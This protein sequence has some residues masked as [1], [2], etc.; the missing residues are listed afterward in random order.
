[1]RKMKKVLALAAC[2]VML[3]TASV[4]G[5]LAY[6]TSTDDVNN[7]F[8]VGKVEITLDEARVNEYGVAVTPAVRNDGNE[9]K[10]VPG[11]KY[12]KDPTIH[13]GDDSE[14]CWLF[15]KIENGL[16]DK[17]TINGLDTCGWTYLESTGNTSYWA[18]A[19]AKVGAGMDVKVFDTFTFA[20]DVTDTAE[21]ATK[22]IKVSAYAIQADSFDTADSAWA[23][24][25]AQGTV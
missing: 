20:S 15:V 2:A 11:H 17:A 4:M 22:S 8:T 19:G 16:G 21:Y 14:A 3:V 5:T 9:Y 10:L 13:V 6:L 25:K 24:L 18:Y 7:T 23:A 12:T 1:M